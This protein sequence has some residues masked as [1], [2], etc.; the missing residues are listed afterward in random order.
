MKYLID[1]VTFVITRIVQILNIRIFSDFS[2]TYFELIMTAF[3]LKFIFRFIFGGMKEF[4]MQT[5][6]IG[7]ALTS[8][9]SNEVRKKQLLLKNE[10]K[11]E[12]AIHELDKYAKIS[13]QK[14]EFNDFHML[15]EMADQLRISHY[16]EYHKWIK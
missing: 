4:E 6:W 2:L 8:K 12:K 11:S 16:D 13:L 14:K 1:Y 9:M 5:N 15:S 7:S 10:R 3:I